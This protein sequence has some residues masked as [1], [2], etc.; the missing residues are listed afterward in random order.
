MSDRACPPPRA[1]HVPL[2]AVHELGHAWGLLHSG[3]LTQEYGDPTCVL[4]GGSRWDRTEGWVT[5]WLPTFGAAQRLAAG[6]LQATGRLDTYNSVPST[7]TLINLYKMRPAFPGGAV[8]NFPDDASSK[9]AIVI[10][11]P[12]CV[13]RG[14]PHDASTSTWTHNAAG[15]VVIAYRNRLRASDGEGGTAYP[16]LEYQR[17]TVQLALQNVFRADT[18]HSD[19]TYIYAILDAG[20]AHYVP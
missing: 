6:W 10:A 7:P 15:W 8:L 3:G 5:N 9:A 1:A 4:G 19:G 16:N 12:D 20:E 13:A 14:H 17:V 18:P 2:S 11:C